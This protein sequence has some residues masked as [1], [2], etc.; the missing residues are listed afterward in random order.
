M[1]SYFSCS[2]TFTHRIHTITN[3]DPLFSGLKIEGFLPKL[4]DMKYYGL[5]FILILSISCRDTEELSPVTNGS[6]E[7]VSTGEIIRHS[8]YTLSYSEKNEQA[9]WVFYHLSSA[10]NNGTQDRTDDFRADP[11]VSTG[12][13]KLSDYAGS[14]YDRGHLCPAADMTQNKIS[15]SETFFLSNMSPQL[16]GFNRGIWSTL[17]DQVRKWSAKYETIY[18]VTGPVFENNLG[19]IGSENVTVPG[20]YYKIIFD[21]KNNM[22]GLILPNASSSKSLD[23]FVVP[24]DQIEKETSIDFFPGLNDQLE[25]KLEAN[26]DWNYWKN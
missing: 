26:T 12:S 9:A 13:A 22:I 25:N 10:I 4:T 23:Q 19:V 15:M 6:F 3:S 20:S 1:I 2:Q 14:G 11:A 17:E 18:I 16:A 21:G 24:V 7:P 5:L 8:Y